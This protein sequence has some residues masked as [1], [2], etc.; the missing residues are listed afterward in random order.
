[1]AEKKEDVDLYAELEKE[2]KG[3]KGEEPVV[4]PDP[5]PKEEDITPKV[6][7]KDENAELTEEDISKLSPRAQKRI[8][9]QAEKIKELS[10]KEIADEKAKEIAEPESPK[11]HE[12]KDVQEFLNA[13]EDPQSRKLLE[14]FY[15]VIKK[16]T[17]TILS[18]VEEANNKAKFE[19][20]FG[21]YEKVEGMADYKEEL[22]K[23]FLRNPNQDIDSLFAKTVTDLTLNRIKKLDDTPS[24][25]NRGGEV[26]LESLDKDQLYDKL[27]SMRGN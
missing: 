7:D 8:R 22:K 10:A 13:V 25:P 20:T 14:T 23:T 2:L 18:P 11:T 3:S 1:M 12:F 21:K 5:K 24:A 26:D 27:E 4:T 15:G 9:E 6:D 17:S 19:Q 16:E